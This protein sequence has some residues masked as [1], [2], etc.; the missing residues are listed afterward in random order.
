[1]FDPR[2]LKLADGLVNFSCAVKPGENVLIESIGGNEDLVRALIKAV[3]KAGGVPFLWLEDKRLD[4]EII[5]HCTQEQLERRAK[6]D[7]S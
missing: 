2:V 5:M 6:V 1:M 3:Y 4:R 7:A